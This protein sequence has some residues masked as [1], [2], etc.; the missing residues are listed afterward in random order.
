MGSASVMHLARRGARVLGLDQFAP[1]H[2]R[3]SSHGQSRIIREAYFEHP[4]YVPLVQRAYEL[5]AGLEEVAGE[6][7]FLPT[8]GLMIGRPESAVVRGARLSAERHRLR[9]EVLTATEVAERFPAFRLEPE[10]VAVWE[11]RAGILSPE[12]CVAA[13][14]AQA[15]QAGAM[16]RT[17]ETL[18]KWELSGSGVRVSTTAGEYS[19]GRLVLSVGGWLPSLAPGLAVPMVVERQVQFWF[20]PL[21]RPEI[22]RPEVSP[23]YL[24]EFDQ[25]RQF[26]GFPDL[27]NGVKT[28]SHHQGATGHPDT[29]DRVARPADEAQAREITRRFLPFANGPVRASAVCFYTTTPDCHFLI[30][31]HPASDR[32]LIA[33]P[34][35]GHGFKFSSAVGEV[36]TDLVLTGRSRFDL[37]LFR[38]GPRG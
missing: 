4:L 31:W 37:S 3:G 33:S 34:C 11:P 2:D 32:V 5:W 27:G 7:L 22:F 35:S 9:H 14:L 38:H 17:N 1:P 20:E 18:L 29:L 23:I 12:K 6:R 24:G 30:D 15:G 16:I 13:H 28:A 8:G 10:M 21:E 25:G 26:Y 36:A 19:A